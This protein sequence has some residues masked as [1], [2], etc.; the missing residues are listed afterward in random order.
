MFNW[1]FESVVV[2]CPPNKFVYFVVKLLHL[3]YSPI[4]FKEYFVHI[5]TLVVIVGHIPIANDSFQNLLSLISLRFLRSII[6]CYSLRYHKVITFQANLSLQTF[7]LLKIRQRINLRI[8]CIF[9]IN[10]K[11]LRCALL[12]YLLGCSH[13][14]SWYL[15]I[16]GKYWMIITV[17]YILILFEGLKA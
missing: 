10:Q 7:H 5:S 8:L 11:K 6:D 15:F 13:S 9:L 1:N 2:L 4:L 12:G 16:T 17:I 14:D 3:A